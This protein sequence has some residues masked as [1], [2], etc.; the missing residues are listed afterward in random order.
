MRMNIDKTV[1]G[2]ALCGGGGG[3]RGTGIRAAVE[4]SFHAANMRSTG[5]MN[6]LSKGIAFTPIANI[7]SVF[8]VEA[9]NTVRA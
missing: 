8:V 5:Q 9:Y 1:A 4:R 3:E 7:T 6:E 2:G